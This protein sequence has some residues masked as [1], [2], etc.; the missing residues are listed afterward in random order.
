MGRLFASWSV[1]YG[2]EGEH[3]ERD[4]RQAHE[5]PDRE[6]EAARARA[7]T[8]DAG[9]EAHRYTRNCGSPKTGAMIW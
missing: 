7:R 5:V 4:A 3:E 2:A 8:T 9:V 1:R 6:L